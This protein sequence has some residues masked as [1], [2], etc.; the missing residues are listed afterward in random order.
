MTIT[1]NQNRILHA[2]FHQMEIADEKINR[3]RYATNGRTA[4]IT[5]MNFQEAQWLIDTLR[6]ERKQLFAKMWGRLIFLCKEMGYTDAL[7]QEDIAKIDTYVQNIGERNPKKRGLWQLH[8]SE[9]RA[10]LQQIE[11]RYT[12]TIAKPEPSEG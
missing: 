1:N 10:V 7:G 6:S 5:E 12:N 8:H 4:S 9:L 11:A 2:L 3:V